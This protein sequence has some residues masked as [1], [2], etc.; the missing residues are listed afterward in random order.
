MISLQSSSQESDSTFTEVSA[1]ETTDGPEITFISIPGGSFRM[2]T[3]D[4]TDA[5]TS[6]RMVT[7]DSFELSATEITN[8][9]YCVYLNAA[10]TADELVATYSSVIGV[11]G[12]HAGKE[13]LNIKGHSDPNNR[14]WIGYIDGEFHIPDDKKNWPVVFVTWYGADTFA[15]NY[16]LDLPTAAEW[17]YA[18]RGGRQ[19]KYSTDDGNISTTKINYARFTGHPVAV[20]SY[21]AN[22]FG[23][24]DMS[25][26]VWE[27]C[28]DWYTEDY[29]DHISQR[30]P[31]GPDFGFTRIFRGGSWYSPAFSCQT[32]VIASFVPGLAYNNLGFRVVRRSR[33]NE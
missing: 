23:F 22:P 14:C 24:F 20:G 7:L 8:E 33:N 26:N 31:T 5:D 13:Y 15:E 6:D 11:T 16:G 12:E 18:A 4:T 19:L 3:V 1:R 9:Q 10:L 17:E 28:G 25:G 29:Y 30:N 32:T 2:G 21:Q 27:W